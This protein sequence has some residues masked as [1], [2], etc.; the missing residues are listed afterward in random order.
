M[1]WWWDR[2]RGLRRW[3]LWVDS[4]FGHRSPW[5]LPWPLVLNGMDFGQT[6]QYTC[7]GGEHSPSV[8]G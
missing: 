8:T 7:S 2:R 1:L 3:G 4:A 6:E 5:G